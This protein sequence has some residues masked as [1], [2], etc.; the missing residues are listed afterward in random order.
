VKRLLF[1]LIIPFVGVVFLFNLTGE[2]EEVDI[3]QGKEHYGTLIMSSE[4]E[5]L[6]IFIN[7]KQV[8]VTQKKPQVFN[9]P[10][11]GVFGKADHEVVVQKE[12][13]ATHEY[14]FY[15]SFCFNRYIDVEENPVE[16]IALFSSPP[17]NDTFPPINH[18][19]SIRLKPELLAR[20]TGLVQSKKLKHNSAW[21]MA[22]DE[23]RIF[24]LSRADKDLD[25]KS[26]NEEVEGEFLEVYDKE[27]FSFIGQRQLSY[28]NKTFSTYCSIAVGDETIYIGDRNGHL[29]FI[30]KQSLEPKKASEKLAGFPEKVSGLVTYRDYLLAFGEGDLIAV[31]KSEKLLYTIDEEVYY[32]HN[33][34]EIHDYSDINRI[35]SVAIHNGV[36]YASNYY[37]FINAYALT[38]GRFIRQINTIKFEEEWGYVV[39]RN[40]EA[41]ALY[42]DRYLY[43]SQD[44]GGVSMFDT[45]TE[46]I[47]H[48]QTLF[49]R[50]I[51]HSKLF[52][53]D[54]DVT[55][56]T[57][58]YKMLFFS[59]NLIFSEVNALQNFVY[60]YDLDIGRI[61]NTFKGHKGDITELFLNGER[62]VGLSHEGLLYRW[63]LGVIEESTS[64][65]LLY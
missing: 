62:L 14:Y 64:A 57:D 52:E 15:N 58:I 21:N 24:V 9:L 55:K 3:L 46:N 60:V 13:D 44:Y 50:K 54:I 23:S 40:I 45:Q 31:F 38:D 61:V 6:P 39:G 18:A 41:S 16:H 33:I 25:R 63:D 7:E 59:H 10:T 43:F 37:G 49:P 36:L 4:I 30:D 51:V 42:Q 29:Q 34:K 32:P 28:E 35:N 47:S 26:K 2:N 5:G 19:I 17:A 56:N 20:Q 53:K 1:Y 22:Q 12:I 8:G 65:D 48:I 27:T 11:V